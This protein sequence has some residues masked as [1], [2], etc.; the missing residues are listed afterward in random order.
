MTTLNEEANRDPTPYPNYVT[1][2]YGDYGKRKTTTACSMVNEKGLLLCSDDSWKV[3]LNDRHTDLRSKIKIIKLEG[4]SQLQYID[5][6]GFDTII[7]DT[8]SRSVA[9]YIDLLMVHAKWSGNNREKLITSHSE[10]KSLESTSASD[11]RILRDTFRPILETLF[12]RDTNLVFT[13]QMTEPIQGL[14]K[15]QRHRPTIPAATFSVIAERADIIGNIKP[16][17][18]KFVV[19]MSENALT[20]LGKSRT[21]GLQGQMDLDSFVNKYKEIVFK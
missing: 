17:N 5:Y 13:S 20:M 16:M 10:L 11:Y 18:R 15:D 6:E 1:V 19:D 12:S 4:L 7:W 2:L 21:E 3:L 8:V 14:S 9:S